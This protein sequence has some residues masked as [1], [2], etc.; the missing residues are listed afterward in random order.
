MS[1]PPP[2]PPQPKRCCH[3]SP[4]ERPRGAHERGGPEA[5]CSSSH[6][7]SGAQSS[8][9]EQCQRT[10]ALRC[11]CC[12]CGPRDHFCGGS[13]ALR[14]L[15]L[16]HLLAHELFNVS[17]CSPFH[18]LRALPR[19]LQQWL[20]F[21]GP[22]DDLW[23]G[24]FVWWGCKALGCARDAQVPVDPIAPPARGVVKVLSVVRDGRCRARQ[25]RRSSRRGFGLLQ[26]AQEA[27]RCWGLQPGSTAPKSD[28]LS[29]SKGRVDGGRARHR[30]LP[31]RPRRPPRDPRLCGAAG[32]AEVRC[33][34]GSRP[35]RSDWKS[36]WTH[37]GSGD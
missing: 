13:E 3:H 28:S 25:S 6:T 33:S 1:V 23:R 32:P 31:G 34:A 9:A 36:G 35:A 15:G 37:C 11:R 20:H 7:R 30:N 29:R 5:S 24:H 27:W 10:G 19:A 12:F 16:G 26:S 2:P 21:A 17:G 18:F 4:V 14:G 22:A 8:L